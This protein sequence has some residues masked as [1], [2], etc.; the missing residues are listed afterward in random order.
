MSDPLC[1]IANEYAG[2]DIRAK[3]NAAL[4][5]LPDAGGWVFVQPPAAPAVQYNYTT[6]IVIGRDNV[7]LSGA[8]EGAV[9]LR[10]TASS[11]CPLTVG[12]SG[13][14]TKYV[15]LSD[16]SIKM[17]DSTVPRQNTS[18]TLRVRNCISCQFERLLIV[19]DNGGQNVA[20]DCLYVTSHVKDGCYD[21]VF[22]A[23]RMSGH[24]E[25]ALRLTT[26]G[27]LRTIA[28]SPNGAT[29]SSGI[30]RITTTSGHGYE[31]DHDVTVE[32]V[33]GGGGTPF[34]GT[35]RITAVDS[36]WFEYSQAGPDSSGGGRQCYGAGFTNKCI[37]VGLYVVGHPPNATGWRDIEIGS[38]GA[39]NKCNDHHFIGCRLDGP[40]NDHTGGVELDRSSHCK[41]WGMILDGYQDDEVLKFT[42]NAEKHYFSGYLDGTYTDS[43]SDN[44][45]HVYDAHNSVG[46][47][48]FPYPVRIG[49]YT[50]PATDGTSG[51]V[52]KTDGAGH[53]TWQNV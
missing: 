18:P 1:L 17:A 46:L 3:I 51:Q 20:Q 15:T 39:S 8:Q 4:A 31:V 52:L 45:L 27:A 36:T 7:R 48:K 49:A 19:S 41:F 16:L 13:A 42:S 23:V 12:A 30:V 29:R 14:N 28:A 40:S 22:N 43:G 34:N 2:A 44:E 6:P 25:F 50:L 33:T 47:H 10:Y 24:G 37:F 21:N 53:V 32:S 26:E 11:G 35:F 9:L 38:R 5:D